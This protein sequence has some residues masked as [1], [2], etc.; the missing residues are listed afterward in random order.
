MVVLQLQKFPNVCLRLLRSAQMPVRGKKPRQV[1][2]ASQA[3]NRLRGTA[4]TA[5]EHGPNIAAE[6]QLAS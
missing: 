4:I 5:A 3:P 2:R 1:L 6:I